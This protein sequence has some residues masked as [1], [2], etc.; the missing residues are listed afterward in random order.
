MKSIDL[1]PYFI[2]IDIL[3]QTAAQVV[4]DFGQEGHDVVF[5][6]DT[7]RAYSELFIQ[8]KP[9]LL[10]LSQGN[11]QSFLNLLYRIDVNEKYIQEHQSKIQTLEYFDQLTDAVLQREMQK[12]ITRN[13]FKLQNDT[14]SKRD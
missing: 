8:I 14:D 3:Q 4:K 1:E 12:V 6:G 2:N 10:R 5:S 7:Q 11:H 13:Y 9:I